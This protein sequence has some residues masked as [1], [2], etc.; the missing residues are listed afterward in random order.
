[1][2]DLFISPF[3]SSS[4]HQQII[5]FTHLRQPVQSPLAG[6]TALVASESWF[7]RRT[8]SPTI[9]SGP[10]SSHFRGIYGNIWAAC[11][12]ISH[13]CL[14]TRQAEAAKVHRVHR[15]GKQAQ[16]SEFSC[17]IMTQNNQDEHMLSEDERCSHHLSLTH[18]CF[19][20]R[21]KWEAWKCSVVAGISFLPEMSSQEWPD[22]KGCASLCC[23]H[24]RF[25]VR[26]DFVCR[27]AVEPPVSHQVRCLL[28]FW[29]LIV[30]KEAEELISGMIWFSSSSWPLWTSWRDWFS[31]SAC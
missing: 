8:T 19:K 18:V 30:Q 11:L 15:G 21:G 14:V 7:T 5:T 16:T 26:F 13:H 6:L 25:S 17:S 28:L 29:H 27:A 12:Q 9:K 24:V 22:V 23:R 4:P 20:T 10:G 2:P 1:M 3:H 31:L